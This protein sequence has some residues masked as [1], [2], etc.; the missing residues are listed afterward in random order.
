[1]TSVI[2]LGAMLDPRDPNGVT[3]ETAPSRWDDGSLENDLGP[4]LFHLLSNLPHDRRDDALKLFR[5]PSEEALDNQKLEKP[6]LPLSEPWPELKANDVLNSAKS[7]E[8][9][10][11]WY[12]FWAW[13][14]AILLLWPA[15]VYLIGAL[16]LF[17]LRL[18]PTTVAAVRFRLLAW[19]LTML[20]L[21]LNLDHS[22]LDYPLAL[23]H[24][25]SASRRQPITKRSSTR[26]SSA[27]N[28]L[29]TVG[30]CIY[31]GALPPLCCHTYQSANE[32]WFERHTAS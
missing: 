15:T 20:H 31:L 12:R 1:M 16:L 18:A 26:P 24:I 6:P 28:S 30:S 8:N 2:P 11:A 29:E 23:A 10:R 5:P 27:E 17:M 7:F 19:L 32:G 14:L 25:A 21:T 9:T 3:D 22:P 4:F 13:L